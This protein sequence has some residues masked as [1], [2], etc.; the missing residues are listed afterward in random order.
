MDVLRF[1]TA[2]SVDDGKSTLIGRLLYDS[3]AVFEDQL[4]AVRRATRNAAAG[5][6]DLSLLTDGLRAERE[7]GITIDV[8]YRYFATPRRKFIIADTPGHEQYTRNMATGSSNAE[9][10]IILV[11]ARRGVQVQSRRHAYIAHLLGIRRLIFAVNKMDLVGYE[12]E[13]FET[14]RA[15][16]E[17]FA[18][19]LG[20]HAPVFIPISALAGDNV[21]TRSVAMPWYE[22]PSLLEHLE[23]VEV[24]ENA[25]AQPFRLPVQLVLRP[26]QH[27]RGYAGEIASGS[28][29]CGDEVVVLPSGK[30]TRVRAIHSA[31][32]ECEAAHAH[33]AVALQLADEI[34]ISRGDLLAAPDALP[35]LTREFEA[36]VVWLGDRP[37]D[38]SRPYLLKHTTRWE[39]ARVT[40]IAHR[41]DVNT[42]ERH[43]ASALALNEIGIVRFAAAQPLCFDAYED[44]RRTGS[45]ILVDLESNDTVAAGMLS[46]A[47][48]LA[49]H[50]V[51]W[52][53]SKVDR[54]AREASHNYRGAVLWL[55]G[56][57]C[58]GKSSI[59]HALEL[60]LFRNGVNAYV[61]DGDNLRHGLC[62]DLGFSAEDRHEN[63]RRGAEVAKILVDAGML[64]I[65]SFVSPQAADRTYVRELIGEQDFLELYVSTPLEVCEQRDTHELYRRARAGEIRNFTG[66]D[67]PYES[68]A[69]PDLVLP[70]HEI[71][72]Q[73]AVERV[74]AVLA[75]RKIYVGLNDLPVSTA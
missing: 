59:A 48:P 54:H 22:G 45:F 23:T 58:S 17:A 25:A 9:L 50:N 16:L 6:V 13:V 38:P 32:H 68:P 72:V 2:G 66:V 75:S 7:Q 33:M 11:D 15:E 61:L 12:R 31:G 57:P 56:L 29:R 62:G 70:A 27:Y 71:G 47:A 18:E 39:R 40:H 14:I 65:A 35:H 46:R 3:K 26:H 36:S 19:R 67:A 63:L 69:Q 44:N 8:A 53:D 42:L 49:S 73:E 37:L 30:R 43:H 1:S 10:S 20:I 60:R 41:I 52:S 28:I 21:V 64:V 34:D 51:F 55:T 24:L 5:E 4:D 74:L